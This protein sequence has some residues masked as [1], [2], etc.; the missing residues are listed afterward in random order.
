MIFISEEKIVKEYSV[1]IIERKGKYF[2]KL[3]LKTEEDE[4]SY[5]LEWGPFTRSLAIDLNNANTE[6]SVRKVYSL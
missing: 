3:V 6:V 2:I 1:D 5:L 4:D